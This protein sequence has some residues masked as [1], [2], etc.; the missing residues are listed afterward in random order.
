[1]HNRKALL[2]YKAFLFEKRFEPL[3]T[4]FTHFSIYRLAKAF[5][6]PL[7]SNFHKDKTA[8]HSLLAVSGKLM[9]RSDPFRIYFSVSGSEY[10]LHKTAKMNKG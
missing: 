3:N 1:M 6:F 8:Q 2:D 4:N 7:E 10:S 9:P 5:T